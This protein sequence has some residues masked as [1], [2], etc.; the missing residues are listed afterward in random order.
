MVSRLERLV[1]V[2]SASGSVTLTRLL[3][4]AAP[5][6]GTGDL[7]RSRRALGSLNTSFSRSEGMMV[8]HPHVEVLHESLSSVDKLPPSGAVLSSGGTAVASSNPC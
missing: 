3:E 1:G 4:L 2:R 5:R 7:E 6:S 8:R